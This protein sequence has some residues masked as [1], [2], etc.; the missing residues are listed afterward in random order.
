MSLIANNRKFDHSDFIANPKKY[1][2]FQ[3]A[4]VASHV[5]TDNGI[6]DLEE[7]RYVSVQFMRTAYNGLRH[8]VEPVYSVTADGKVWGV[9]FASGLASF[10][11]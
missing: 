7:G 6:D 3:I 4:R 9:M 5:F 8:R 10:V 2:L 11:L 1:E